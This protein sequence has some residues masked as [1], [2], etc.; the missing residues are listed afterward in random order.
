MVPPFPWLTP[1][2]PKIQGCR[3]FQSMFRKSAY[4]NSISN[5][6]RVSE[7]LTVE[8]ILRSHVVTGLN[9]TTLDYTDGNL[10]TITDFCGRSLTLVHNSQNKLV[11]I[12]DSLNRNTTLEYDST[13]KKLLK[14]TDPE[15]ES[16]QYSYNFMYQ[17]TGKMD[18]DGKIFSYVYQNQ[19]P[20]AIKDGVGDT[21]F[22][23]ANPNNWAIDRTALARNLMYE[24]IP[25]T[26]SKTDGRGNVWQYEYDK[27]GYL[28][29]VIASDDCTTT[30]TY[31]PATLKVASVTDSNGN[32]TS[33]EYDGLVRLIKETDPLLGVTQTI[34]DGE[35]N[36]IQIIDCNNNGT[37]YEYDLRDRVVKITDAL[38]NDITYT[39]DGNDNRISETDKN[40]NATTFEYDDQNRLIEIIDPPI[41]IP[42]IPCVT[43]M[44]YDCVGNKLTETDGNGNTT[45]YEY[46][47]LNRLIKQTD[48]VDCVT[49]YEYD[50]IGAPGCCGGTIGTSLITKQIDGNGNIT[51]FKYCAIGR[52]IQEIRK[53]GDTDCEIIDADDAVTEY[54]YD[55]NGNRLS[56]SVRITETEYLT[57]T[58]E[59]DAKNQLIQE[60]NPASDETSY[61]YDCVGNVITITTPNGN[62]TT[63]AYDANNRPIQVEDLLGLVAAYTYDCIGN[64]LSETDGNGNTTWFEYDAIYRLVKVIDSMLEETEYV[65]DPVGNP[66]KVIDRELNETTHTYDALNR[67]IS[68][69]D[70]LGYVTTYEYD[71]VGNLLKI[72]DANS[73]PTAYEYDAVNR[74][75]NEAYADGGIRTF[76]Y[77]CVGNL[78]TRTDQ[79]GQTTNYVYSDL[80]FLMQRNYP[81]SPADNFTYDLSGRMLIAERGSWLVTFAYDGANRGIQTTQNSQVIDYIY[82]I[83]GRTRT[84]IY[85]NGRVITE[86]MDL[87]A[88]LDTIDDA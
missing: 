88:R 2:K 38:S 29:K 68:T 47:P 14:I 37:F 58:Y 32:T 35:G 65:Y 17:L 46:D 73:N 21:L 83:P 56:V 10:A 64:R 15:L 75:I 74:L 55:P 22:S 41:G 81:A 23:L 67:R 31:D 62:V 27:H 8:P 3:A 4:R 25:S 48:A 20:V 57:T 84:I 18:K 87:R 40:D 79:K 66:L 70:D 28:T 60:T 76:T 53:Q 42:P 61:T 36:I 72:I 49:E 12:K 78:L 7:H 80:Y 24:Y 63:S 19:K 59:Y 52:L 30:Y 13:G 34:Y 77:D 9:T 11:S 85:P 39:Y 71:C 1:W 43:T 45:T 50:A 69:T 6:K 82:D 51:C 16:I 86:Q 44:T 54:S 33:Y 26:T 5:K